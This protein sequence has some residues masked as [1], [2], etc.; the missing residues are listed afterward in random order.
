[1]REGNVN[2][3][4]GIGGDGDGDGDGVGWGWRWAMG[5]GMAMVQHLNSFDGPINIKFGD[6]GKSGRLHY[7]SR[8]YLEFFAATL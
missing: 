7:R 6:N 5:M 4:G 2:G 8:W 3:D 1:M